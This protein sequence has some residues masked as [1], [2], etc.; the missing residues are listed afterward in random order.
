MIKRMEMEIVTQIDATIVLNS[1][2]ERKYIL[3]RRTDRNIMSN[4]VR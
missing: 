4:P 2:L 1:R 3:R